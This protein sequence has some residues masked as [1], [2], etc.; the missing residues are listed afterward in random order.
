MGGAK[1]LT[2]LPEPGRTFES[3]VKLRFKYTGFSP[4]ATLENGGEKPVCSVPVR[5][6]SH[7]LGRVDRNALLFEQTGA[8]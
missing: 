8:R 1:H 6:Q 4:G 5:P 7:A 2:G 3:T